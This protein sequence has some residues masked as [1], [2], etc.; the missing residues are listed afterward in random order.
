MTSSAPDAVHAAAS[1]QSFERLARAGYVARGVVYILMGVL[2]VQ[3]ARGVAGSR[4]SQEGAMRLVAGHPFGRVVLVVLAVGLLGYTLLRLTQAF[5][6]RTPEAGEYSL[7]DRIGAFG[8]ACAYGVFFATAI[9][10]LVGSAGGGGKPQS[11]TSDVLGWPGGRILVAIAGA[12]FIVVAGYQAYLG[13]TRSFLKDSKSMYMSPKGLRAF[14]V[15]GVVGHLARTVVFGLVG[16]FLVKAAA[17]YDPSQAVGVDGALRRL[18]EHTGG[19]I[20]LAVVAA[21]LVAFGVYSIT[22]ARYRKI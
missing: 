11:A 17:E 9:A 15:L 6:G 14:T 21:G 8:S 16:A 4:P 10:I 13:L 19:T 20:A 18:T 2:A 1:T 22:D 12:V 5:A 7:R 3:L